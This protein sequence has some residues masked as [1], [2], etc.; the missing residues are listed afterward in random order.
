MTSIDPRDAGTSANVSVHDVATRRPYGSSDESDHILV[1]SRGPDDLAIPWITTRAMDNNS[2]DICELPQPHD[3]TMFPCHRRM[4][5]QTVNDLDH[6]S[7]SPS[8]PIPRDQPDPTAQQPLPPIRGPRRTAV[9]HYTAEDDCYIIKHTPTDTAVD[10]PPS[11]TGM[12]INVQRNLPTWPAFEAHIAALDLSGDEEEDDGDN[13][14]NEEATEMS[15]YSTKLMSKHYLASNKT[16][17][18]HLPFTPSLFD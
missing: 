15:G 5:V 6:C 4:P 16:K 3:T 14:S 10:H 18:L 8:T 2:S 17:S 9:D 1:G 7:A 13:N 12:I 11:Q